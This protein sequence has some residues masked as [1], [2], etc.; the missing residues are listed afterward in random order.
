MQELKVAICAVAKNENKYIKEWVDYH[1]HL[2]F[3][4]IFIY[5]NNDSNSEKISD[6]INNDKV[7]IYDW[8]NIQ[9]IQSK[10]YT[11]CFN[12]QK[13]NFDWI[14]YIDI[15]EFV[16][17]E[18][19]N[20]IKQFLS[21]EYF[22][23]TYIIR[24]N[25]MHFDDNDELDIINDNYNVFNRFHNRIKYFKDSYGK[26]FIR[27]NLQIK[28]T[29]S[30]HGYCNKEDLIPAVNAIGEQ[31]LNE[32]CVVSYEPLYK[33]AWINHYR[34]KTIGEYI[35]QKFF[36]GDASQANSNRYNNLEFFFETNKR[37]QE[38]ENYANK[39]LKELN[40]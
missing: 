18:K 40:G 11:D 13:N 29:I 21:N 9:S 36:R 5:D 30:A 23:N 3:D 26:S 27:T 38:K 19:Y 28:K 39:L 22:N 17:L 10:A 37:T 1:L 2:G 34:T 25:W 31:C 20:N 24:L 32:N 35:R 16:V 12:N 8:F 33:G 14:L 7:I 4:N 6:I 15:D